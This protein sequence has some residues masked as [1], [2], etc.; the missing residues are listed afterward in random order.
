M[1]KC[2]GYTG[3][4]SEWEQKQIDWLAAIEVQQKRLIAEILMACIF[5]SIFPG[6]SPPA[7]WPNSNESQL[8]AWFAYCQSVV[9]STTCPA[10]GS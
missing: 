5:P 1:S 2:D 10:G 9:A 3:T 6:F 8:N 4:C 7:G